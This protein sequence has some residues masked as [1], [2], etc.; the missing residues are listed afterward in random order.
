M[1]DS[2]GDSQGAE[3]QAQGQ[4]ADPEPGQMVWDPS[5]RPHAKRQPA[6]LATGEWSTS[7]VLV[8][9]FLLVSPGRTGLR[10]L[11]DGCLCFFM[12]RE[13]LACIRTAHFCGRWAGRRKEETLQEL[14][15]MDAVTCILTACHR[16]RVSVRAYGLC[17][18]REYFQFLKGAA[19]ALQ[20]KGLGVV[21]DFKRKFERISGEFQLEGS[22]RKERC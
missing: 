14:F 7:S 6:G 17:T 22:S 16:N 18:E 1:P 10:L 4:D 9:T 2:G 13:L 8:K 3:A 11:S 5:T 20:R 12:L 15:P 21:I 19:A